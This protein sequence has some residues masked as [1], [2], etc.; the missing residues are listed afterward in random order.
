MHGM[1]FVYISSKKACNEGCYPKVV[2]IALL[3]YMFT[4]NTDMEVEL[5]Q[6][7]CSGGASSLWR[8]PTSRE[9]Q[10]NLC[11]RQ[12]Q[13]SGWE[14]GKPA[15]CYCS[16]WS[17]HVDQWLDFCKDFVCL[18]RLIHPTQWLWV[19]VWNSRV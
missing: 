5:G 6:T 12:V 3:L 9:R 7:D 17:H 14:V 8:S 2:G 11:C 15:I 19:T 18:I 13:G 1:Q 16:H 4:M 10:G